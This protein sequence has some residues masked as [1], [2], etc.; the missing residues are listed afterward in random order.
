MVMRPLLPSDTF[1]LQFG[2]FHFMLLVLATVFIAA[3]GYI[4]NDYFDTQ[5][6]LINKPDRVVVGVRIGRRVAM[7]LHAILNILGIG[8]G[9]YLSLYIGLTVLSFV[10]ILAT[11]LLWFYS[12]SYKRQFLVGNI[13]VAFLTG[14]VPMLVVLFE[15]PLLNREYGELM[16]QHNLNFNYMV[17]WVGGFSFFAF[18]TTLIREV[19]KDMEDFEGDRAYGMK[20]LPIVL[21]IG[22]T[23]VIVLVL[24]VMVMIMLVFLLIRHILFSVVPADWIS[25][26]YFSLL[27]ILPL[28]LLGGR[29]LTAGNK[30]HYH[31][32]SI[33]VKLIMLTG[34]LYSVVVYNLVTFKY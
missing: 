31:T 22:W 17:A 26:A 11:G 25:L 5:T 24:T 8:I 15:I 14:L 3:A 1:S 33:L 21:G 7:I 29:I 16:I 4:I 20:T 23:K 27:L 10:F 13:S 19:I 30:K 32:A 18:M 6:D 9:I 34:I 2:E 12:T 28:I